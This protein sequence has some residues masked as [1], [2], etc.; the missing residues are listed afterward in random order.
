M[1]VPSQPHRPGTAW[2]AWLLLLE[3]SAP[4]KQFLELPCPHKQFLES[5]ACRGSQVQQAC[6]GRCPCLPTRIPEGA[7]WT[8]PFQ[9][10]VPFLPSRVGAGGSIQTCQSSFPR[11]G[12][13]VFLGRC[14]LG[15]ENQCSLFLFRNQELH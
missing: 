12:E 14:P 10:W 8:L 6:L 3:P 4:H 1:D 11:A 13:A 5:Q 9:R 2:D 7:P 15:Q